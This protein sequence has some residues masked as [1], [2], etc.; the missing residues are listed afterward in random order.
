M[1]TITI[2][3]S[4]AAGFLAGI[5]IAP[6]SGKKLRDILFGDPYAPKEHTYNISELVSPD[7]SSLESIRNKIEQ[8]T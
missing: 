6:M 2:I 4:I 5:L 1:K 7:S 8:G 3:G